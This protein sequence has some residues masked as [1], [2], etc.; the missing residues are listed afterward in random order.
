MKYILCVILLFSVHSMS[1]QN[2]L[3]IRRVTTKKGTM[4]D[5]LRPDSKHYKILFSK[6]TQDVDLRFFLQEY[7]DGKYISSNLPNKIQIPIN[8]GDTFVMD[9]VPEIQSNGT[10]KLYLFC[11]GSTSYFYMFPNNG[12]CLKFISYTTTKTLYDKQIMALLVYEDNYNGEIEHF[13]NKYTIKEN[14]QLNLNYDKKVRS[15]LKRYSIFYYIIESK[16]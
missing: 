16:K 1:A 14:S 8:K 13:I 10:F 12:K 11:P 9:F 6:F 7:V 2:N 4:L 15:K 3:G 5:I